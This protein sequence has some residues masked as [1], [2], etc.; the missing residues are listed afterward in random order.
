VGTDRL[1]VVYVLDPKAVTVRN[2]Q[3]SAGYQAVLFDPVTGERSS[4]REVSADAKGEW[5]CD[6]PAHGHDWVLQLTR[7]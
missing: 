6:P 1:R 2:L 7:K 3:P 4:S 5:R